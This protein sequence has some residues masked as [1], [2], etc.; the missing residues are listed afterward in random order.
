MLN[1]DHL[2]GNYSDLLVQLSHVY[3]QLRGDTSG[4][5]NEDSAQVRNFCFSFA[6]PRVYESPR[7]THQ[8][9]ISKRY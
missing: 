9:S 5:K 7:T 3:S 6:I 4:I 8:I 2:Q 1:L